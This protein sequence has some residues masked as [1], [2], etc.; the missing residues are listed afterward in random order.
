MAE[1]GY[2]CKRYPASIKDQYEHILEYDVTAVFIEDGN[3]QLTNLMDLCE[4]G[5]SIIVY[6]TS[7]FNRNFNQYVKLI[8]QLLEKEIELISVRENLNTH[9]DQAY[10]RFI[11]NLAEMEYLVKKNQILRG[12]DK[13]KEA[14]RI[15]GR[16]SISLNV[17]Q[18]ITK[19]YVEQKMPMREIAEVCGVSL[20][21]VHKY[22]NEAKS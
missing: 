8:N 6:H 21:T 5:D 12:L 4:K 1:Y 15:G 18:Q 10:Y 2:M 16:P 9:K 3:S 13:A 7:V 19:L 14:G 11:Q 20:G 22:T 17:Q